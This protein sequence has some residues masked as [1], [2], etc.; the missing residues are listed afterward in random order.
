VPMTSGQSLGVMVKVTCAPLLTG[1]LRERQT[2]REAGVSSSAYIAGWPYQSPSGS[3]Q[4]RF[5][6][7][8]L[9]E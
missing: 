4:T 3:W 9:A 8:L 7:P 6:W 5:G 2:P 1:A